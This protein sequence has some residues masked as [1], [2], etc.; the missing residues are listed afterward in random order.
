MP[1]P[2][3]G[4]RRPEGAIRREM[5]RKCDELLLAFGTVHNE[6]WGRYCY[7]PHSH[8]RWVSE[9][10]LIAWRVS[11]CSAPRRVWPSGYVARRSRRCRTGA[12]TVRWPCGRSRQV[13][14]P[15]RSRGCN[16]GVSSG[17]TMQQAACLPIDAGAH[18]SDQ[19]MAVRSRSQQS[20]SSFPE[21]AVLP[22]L[23]R[24]LAVIASSSFRFSTFLSRQAI[25]GSDPFSLSMSGECAGWPSR[26]RAP[27]STYP[28]CGEMPV[29]KG[30]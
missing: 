18:R 8:R 16:L 1:N 27:A 21:G 26:A 6:K 7:R 24:D 5:R 10:T 17:S 11:F 28:L 19:P 2:G 4:C 25:Q 14:R 9:E 3:R 23:L 15:V 13:W 30:G 20:G 29:D 22:F 12:F